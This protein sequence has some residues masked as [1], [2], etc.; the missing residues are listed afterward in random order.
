MLK[1]TNLYPAPRTNDFCPDS[2]ICPASLLSD[3]VRES[4]YS[5]LNDILLFIV[6]FTPISGEN[7]SVID[8][9]VML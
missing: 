2:T 1:L 6:A 3:R 7:F 4:R 8:T 9:D 5:A